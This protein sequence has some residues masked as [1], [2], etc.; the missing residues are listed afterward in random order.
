MPAWVWRD[1]RF[2]STR[3]DVAHGRRTTSKAPSGV[4]PC[5]HIARDMVS[6]GVLCNYLARDDRN[7]SDAPG[8]PLRVSVYR[9]YGNTAIDVDVGPAVM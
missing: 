3:V 7:I 4:R 1:V 5:T 6:P 8:T 9:R 2:F